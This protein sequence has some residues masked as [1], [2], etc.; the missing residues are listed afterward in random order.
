MVD[1]VHC[2]LIVTL[3][4]A[5]IRKRAKS[6]FWYAC[7]TAPDG[8]QRQ[9]ST[10]LEDRQEA[11][12]A[13]TAAERALRRHSTDP[14]QLRQS[15]ERIAADYQ[16]AQTTNPA[17]WIREWAAAR[18]AEVSTSTFDTYRNSAANI[19]D[20][21]TAAGIT[22]FSAI[23]P[24]FI[25][26]LRNS[27]AAGSSAVTANTKLKHLRIMLNAAVAAGVATTNPAAA[28][29][30]MREK[31]TRRRDFSIAELEIL[32]PTLS[33]DWR[34]MVMLGFYTGQRL[35]DLATLTWRNLDLSGPTITFTAAKTGALVGLP[36]AQ[37]A[38]DALLAL[39]SSDRPESAVFPALAKLSKGARSNAFRRFLVAVG[40]ATPQPRDPKRA[41]PADKPTR[42]RQGPRET[43]EL[44][45]HSL[46][47]S[48]TSALKSS[49]V[50]DSIARAII[51][52]NSAALS[53]RYTHLD[54]A[55]MR[56]AI[57]KLP[58]IGA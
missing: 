52:H 20:A 12:A 27:W 21:L 48:S 3:A 57:E 45:F 39:P 40:L 14:T 41:D 49:G 42:K 16:P 43:S 53:Q 55:T 19:D 30:P 4:M 46:R 36:L 23:T 9:F 50:T 31:K 17:A 26:R 25:T 33:P 2:H 34:A 54:L 11:L 38:V 13:A 51:G 29:S 24:D 44:S 8:K 10:G 58:I 56:T 5:S 7:I 1:S 47:H 35:N 6:K 15:L 32:L 28:V 37:P 22:C 18:K